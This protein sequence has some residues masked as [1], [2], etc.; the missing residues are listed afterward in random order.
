MDG[1]DIIGVMF[2]KKL[3]V[4]LGAFV[5]TYNVILYIICGIVLDSWILPLYSVVTYA[6]ASKTIDFFV[7]GFDRS[8]AAFI[9]TEH[10]KHVCE[11]LSAA[12]ENGITTIDA[13]GYYS[14]TDRTL[15]Y[16]IVNRFQVGKMRNL[17]HSIDPYAYIAIN[18]VADIFPATNLNDLKGETKLEDTG[19]S[20]DAE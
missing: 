19:D 2:A 1:I 6:A 4:S 5:M 18:D 13:K 11:A 15:V 20:D 14:N 9:V 7:E 12:F 10:P 16:F 17:V 8:K 3:G